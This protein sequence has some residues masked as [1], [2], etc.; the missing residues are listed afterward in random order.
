[1]QIHAIKPVVTEKTTKLKDAKP[2]DLVRWSNIN[3]D[4][5]VL[6]G[7]FWI[8][9]KDES[10]KDGRTRLL[11]AKDFT[12]HKV[13]DGDHEVVIHGWELGIKP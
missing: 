8:V 7:A 5:A 6:E 2:G 12:T 4:E 1:M 3:F 10:F 9:V 11:S 13:S